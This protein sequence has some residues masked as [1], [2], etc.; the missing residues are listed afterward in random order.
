M[1]NSTAL[2]HATFP[3][4]R[5][6]VQHH[7]AERTGQAPVESTSGT[8]DNTSR[9][10]QRNQAAEAASA[11]RVSAGDS[12]A[13]TESETLAERTSSEQHGGEAFTA[14]ELQQIEQLEQ[15]DRE[16][17]QHELA[18]QIAG[19]QYTG[20]ASYEYEVGPDG[21]RYVVAGQVPIDYG[22]VPGDP[23]GTIDKMQTVVAA[24]LAPMDPSPKD[25]QVAARARQYMA[26]ALMELAMQ[27]MQSRLED[28]RGETRTGAS[29]VPAD[30]GRM[31][32]EVASGPTDTA[33]LATA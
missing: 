7:A 23:A 16:V 20:G 8:A 3:A 4:L 12:S 13:S 26:E 2:G 32:Q 25:Y 27:R 24:A 6:Q 22:P 30:P 28:D 17:R 5:A 10:E 21:K 11:G 14:E 19:G 1:I 31:Y 15:T 33:Q 18:H 29:E 9:P